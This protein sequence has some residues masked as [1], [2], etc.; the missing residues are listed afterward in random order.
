MHDVLECRYVNSAGDTVYFGTDGTFLNEGS[1][2]DYQWEYTTQYSKVKA[3]N[4]SMKERVLPVVLAGE[5]LFENAEKL[6]SILDYDVLT[7][8]QGTLYI[9]DYFI[10]CY[11][12]ASAKSK[13]TNGKIIKL[14]LSVLSDF[15]WWKE[16]YKIFGASSAYED[17]DIDYP[18]DYLMDYSPPGSNQK[19]VSESV[20]PFEF[21]IVFQGP[22]V[23]PTLIVEGNLYRVYTTILPAERLTINSLDKRVYRTKVRGA[24]ENE[25]MYRDREHYIFEKMPSVDG[26]SKVNWQTGHIV[27]IKAFTERS[28]PRWI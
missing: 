13:Y 9:G 5:S 26:I 17:E 16:V 27:S 28:E 1:I 11:I 24:E 20:G 2:R 12:V 14:N 10:R 15:R 4:K 22:V 3:F 21:E 8:N 23:N 19:F 7:G 18:R 6:Y 25:F